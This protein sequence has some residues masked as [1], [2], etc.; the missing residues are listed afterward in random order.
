MKIIAPAKFFKKNK[1]VEI[2]QFQRFWWA[3]G[4]ISASHIYCLT[5]ESFAFSTR[6]RTKKLKT[7]HR[8]LFFS[9]FALSEF[10]SPYISYVNKKRIRYGFFLCLVSHRRFELRTP[11]LKV[12]CSADWA[13]GPCCLFPT[14][15]IYG[16]AG[17][18]WTYECQSQ[19]LMPY[20]LATAQ[21]NRGFQ[22]TACIL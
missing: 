15:K 2:K 21:Y 20:P 9:L 11:W 22:L 1:T 16:W 13:N 8:Q 7:C 4:D 5:T 18:I 14:K 17:R 10:E 12:M 3:I 6:L 19:S